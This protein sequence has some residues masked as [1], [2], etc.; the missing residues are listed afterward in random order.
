[1]K[2]EYLLL[3]YIT[4]AFS[5]DGTFKVLSKT[6]FASKRYQ[7]GK[8]VFLYQ[9]NT[10]QR[11]TVIVESY[12]GNGQ[13]D[14]VKVQGVNSKEEALEFKGYEIHALKDYQILDKDHYYYTDL[15]GC[16]VLDDK[17]KV[18]G[19][20]SLV[21]EFPA[22]LTLRVKREGKQPDFLVP[23]VKAFIKSVDI[24]KKQIIINVIGGLL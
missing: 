11:M 2:E 5:L 20:V 19:K 7:K 24:E 16:Q 9:P 3:G 15:V 13:F 22:Q 6:D 14:F 8:E 18:L 4:D 23:F 1:M 10:K 21:E 17:G 12:R